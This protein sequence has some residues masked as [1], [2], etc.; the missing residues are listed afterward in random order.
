MSAP[1][2]EL[3]LSLECRFCGAEGHHRCVTK[4]GHTTSHIHAE[5]FYDAKR[6][7]REENHDRDSRSDGLRSPVP[8][9]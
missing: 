8:D 2:K 4:T 6:K 7:L 5:R 3:M 9:A 1:F